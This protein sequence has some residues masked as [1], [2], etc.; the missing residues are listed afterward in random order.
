MQVVCGEG[1]VEAAD[2]LLAWS[3]PRTR[4]ESF[5]KGSPRKQLLEV[6]RSSEPLENPVGLGS[7]HVPDGHVRLDGD[8]LYAHV[9]DDAYATEAV[10]RIAWQIAV[11]R[12]G[13]LLMHGCSFHWNCKGVAA[14]GHS[15]AGKSTLARLCRGHPAHATVLTDEIVHLVPDGTAFGTPFRSDADNAGSPGPAAL[16]GLLLLKHGTVEALDVVEPADALPILLGQMYVPVIPVVGQGEI[17]RRLMAL[18]DTVGVHR[19]T[20]RKDAAVGPFLRDW[21]ST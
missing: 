20:F 18:V 12:S 13:G 2:D 16:K 21:V 19:L 7:P 5:L 6:V 10:L 1:A 4:L 14:I 15:G 3:A 17:R 9:P 8:T 11:H